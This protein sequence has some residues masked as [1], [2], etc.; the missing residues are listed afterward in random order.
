MKRRD[1]LVY[2]LGVAAISAVASKVNA[3]TPPPNLPPEV[4]EN[5]PTAQA[6]GYHKDASKVD[7][8]KWPKHAGADGQ[9]QKC[10]NCQL[11]A[12]KADK[13]GK[14]AC[15]LFQTR[16]VESNGWCNG[17]VAKA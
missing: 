6:L 9:K 10:S 5:E 16:L 13:K 15:T 8:K 12:A 4:A 17:W 3:Q 7:V 11:F 14:G 1:F 2:S